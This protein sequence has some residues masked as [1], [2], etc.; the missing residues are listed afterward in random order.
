MK[1]FLIVFL[2][3]IMGLTAF[4]FVAC[5]DNS[6][7]DNTASLSLYAPDGAP[8]LSVARLLNDREIIKGI[9]VNIVSASTISTFVTGEDLKADI[10]ILP[11]NLASKMLG[12]ALNYQMLGVVTNGNLFLMR[13]GEGE[14]ITN[15]NLNS[16]IGKKVGVINLSNVPGLTFK[17]ILKQNDIPFHTLTDNGALANDKVNL[18]GLADG[19][20]VVPNSDCDFF[21]VPEPAATTKQNA[22][23]NKL[24]ICGSLQQMYGEGNGYPQAVVVAKKSV[25]NNNKAQI[26]NLINSFGENSSWLSSSSTS[27]EMVVNAV[28]SGF[29][30]KEMAPTFTAKN[31]N[32]IVIEN[33]GISFAKASDAKESV[34]SY[35]ASINAISNNAF[36]TPVDEFF[37]R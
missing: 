10:C 29:V 19:T 3:L 4:S 33:C 13:K 1:K 12:N 18:V 34:L 16:L 20:S 25:I 6:E 8:A 5:N 28:I 27:M 32:A 17:A 15:N 11:V 35:L 14:T 7:Q 31:L 37:Y 21:V 9:D 24:T 30:D 2:T 36:S 26:Q 23:Q 22:T